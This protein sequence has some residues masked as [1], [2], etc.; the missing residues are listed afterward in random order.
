MRVS[1]PRLP[2]H[3]RAY[4]LVERDDGVVY[5]LDGG[6]AGPRL[7]HDIVHLVVERELRIQDGI[8]G[9]IA[10]GI[11]FSSMTQVSGR[12][13]PHAAERSRELLRQYRQRGLRAELFAALVTATAALD[14]PTPQRIRA[15][16]AIKLA[17]LP[18]A[19]VDP[20][21][22][23]AAAQAVQVE[24]ARWARLRVGDHLDYEWPVGSQTGGRRSLSSA[25]T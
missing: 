1:F 20:A 16:A 2:D 18:D 22:I 21:A 10:S 11:V 4:S 9:G 7:P 5:Q 24:A 19:E 17:V 13:R 25:R 23:V 14:A 12:R 8:W 15:L 3:R 6:V